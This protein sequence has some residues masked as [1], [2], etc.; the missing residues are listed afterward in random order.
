MVRRLM[1]QK[2]IL[3]SAVVWVSTH[4]GNGAGFGKDVGLIE[5]L[6]EGKK[7]VVS[8]YRL[9]TGKRNNHKKTMF[10]LSPDSPN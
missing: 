8:D 3:R 7:G 5:K 4:M 9:A 6:V 2:P 1:C 10:R